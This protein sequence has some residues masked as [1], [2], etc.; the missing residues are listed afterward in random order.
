MELRQEGQQRVRQACQLQRARLLAQRTLDHSG[1]F[2]EQREQ[3]HDIVQLA[4]VGRMKLPEPF[5]QQLEHEN[6]VFRDCID[7]PW[8]AARGMFLL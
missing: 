6:V 7:L 2:L 8:S 4:A 5:V 3:P 1:A